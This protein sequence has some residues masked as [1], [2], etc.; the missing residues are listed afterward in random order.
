MENETILI[1][2][3]VKLP[4]NMA[5]QEAYKFLAIAVEVNLHTGVIMRADV[6]LITDLGRDFIS[7]IVYGYNMND[8]VDGLLEIFDRRYFGAARRALDAGVKLLFQK[9]DEI[10]QKAV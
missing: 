7:R 9:Y 5:S 10:V 6:S 4:E 1:S 3:H 2:S 8:G